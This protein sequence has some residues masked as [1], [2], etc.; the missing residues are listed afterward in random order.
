MAPQPLSKVNP[1]AQIEVFWLNG[2]DTNTSDLSV[3][4]LSI[5]TT[6]SYGETLW[7]RFFGELLHANPLP[8]IAM[9]EALDSSNARRS[10]LLAAARTI[11]KDSEVDWI[12]AVQRAVKPIFSVRNNFAHHLWGRSKDIPD[13]LLLINTANFSEDLAWNL[14]GFHL[15][16]KG[17]E[18][19]SRPMIDPKWVT[20]WNRSALATAAEDLRYACQAIN[21]LRQTLSPRIRIT[22]GLPPV[23][24]DE[25]ALAQTWLL[26]WARTAAA[27]KKFNRQ[28]GKEQKTLQRF[29]ARADKTN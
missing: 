16:A 20:V 11:L 12:E 14:E 23:P 25:S 13:A 6:A 4:A 10:I 24:E 27:L 7:A 5:I 1:K 26:K 22:F 21:C 8:S 17:K 9:Y 15:K 3:K 18:I 2:P 29:K 19:E 28:R